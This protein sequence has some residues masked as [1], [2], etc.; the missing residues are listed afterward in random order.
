M[1]VRRRDEGK[2]TG[3][4]TFSR[5]MI[6]VWHPYSVI[7]RYSTF[8]CQE[9]MTNLSASI[10]RR[11]G[12]DLEPARATIVGASLANDIQDR[13]WCSTKLVKHGRREAGH[14]QRERGATKDQ[15]ARSATFPV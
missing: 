8:Y 2:R 3:N 15:R 4:D 7:V 5:L 6:G 14:G 11:I 1:H 9:E 12:R 13:L 10:K